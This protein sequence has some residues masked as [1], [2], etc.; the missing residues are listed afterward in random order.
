M[1]TH[2]LAT[3]LLAALVWPAAACASYGFADTPDEA[4]AEQPHQTL[5]VESPVAPAHLGLDTSGL[6]Q[7]LI[8]EL[9]HQGIDAV[10]YNGVS[11]LQ[12]TFTAPEETGYQHFH[13]V[14]LTLICELT[15]DEHPDRRL[16]TNSS[17]IHPVDR[18]SRQATAAGSHRAAEEAAHHAITQIAP[19]VSHAL[20][21]N[22]D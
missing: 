3:L 11:R 1:S 22:R 16:H 19:A 14:E 4:T 13:A 17:A 6:R 7:A 5:T 2:R 8:D 20:S 15:D 18:S 12:C 9:R 21:L 10:A